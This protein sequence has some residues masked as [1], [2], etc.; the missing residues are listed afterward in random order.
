[1]ASVAA[2]WSLIASIVASLWTSPTGYAQVSTLCNAWRSID[3][4]PG[5]PFTASSVRQDVRLDSD[6]AEHTALQMSG[7]VARDSNGRIY[8]E[9]RFGDPSSGKKSTRPI[10]AKPSVNRIYSRRGILDCG[11]GRAISIYPD[12]EIARVEEGPPREPDHIS[13]FEQLAYVQRPS[14]AIFDDLGYKE[15]EGF[16]THGFKVTVLGTEQDK[17]WNGKPTHITEAW[18]S[19]DLSTTMLEIS[20]DLRAQY[21][22]SLTLSHVSRLEPEASLFEIPVG[23]KINPPPQENPPRPNSKELSTP[24]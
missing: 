10:V 4:Q 9:W 13:F 2:K 18:V 5:N 1:M 17:E 8:T 7:S 23:Y 11:G 15:I 19:D 12:L 24:D 22:S 16:L 14:N 20:T 21:K 3:P 6:G